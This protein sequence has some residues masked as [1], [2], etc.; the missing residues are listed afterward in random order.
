MEAGRKILRSNLHGGV[1]AG[2]VLKLI[3]VQ[4][5]LNVLVTALPKLARVGCAGTGQNGIGVSAA[6]VW[7]VVFFAIRD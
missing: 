5:P 4:M 6:K 7:L 2:S 1:A 3:A